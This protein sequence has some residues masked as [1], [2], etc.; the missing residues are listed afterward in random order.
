MALCVVIAASGCSEQAYGLATLGNL[1]G[2]YSTVVM[3][4]PFGYV[5]TVSIVGVG[6][7]NNPVYLGPYTTNHVAIC[8]ADDI[9][10]S[11]LTRHR[12]VFAEGAVFDACFGPA[13]GT[14]TNVEYLRSIIDSS[15]EAER[16]W[17]LFSP[18][19]IPSI[20]FD[21]DFEK[22][23]YLIIGGDR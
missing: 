5:N 8:G 9:S 6:P 14:Q 10:R 23:D 22:R 18:F 11:R 1:L 20:P 2:I 7:C 13:L 19:D 17:G 4:Q 12:Y 21:M 15:T 16:L 3:T